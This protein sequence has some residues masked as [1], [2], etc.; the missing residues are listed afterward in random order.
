MYLFE[1]WEKS[2][3]WN[4]SNIADFF[5]NCFSVRKDFLVK[6]FFGETLFKYSDGSENSEVV[7]DGWLHSNLS[8]GGMPDC[9]CLSVTLLSFG[10]ELSVRIETLSSSVAGGC[11]ENSDIGCALI[12]EGGILN[13]SRRV[14]SV[15]PA[16]EERSVKPCV[17]V[18]N[19]RIMC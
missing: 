12:E 1:P 6:K 15:F 13:L 11:D 2:R 16:S 7:I 14:G 4:F 5:F 19:D 17:T 9:R 18:H 10:E 3:A 8:K